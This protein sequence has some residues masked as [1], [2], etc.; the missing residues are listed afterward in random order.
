MIKNSQSL[1]S[2]TRQSPATQTTQRRLSVCVTGC[3]KSLTITWYYVVHSICDGAQLGLLHHCM[4]CTV[5]KELI[6]CIVFMVVFLS[7]PYWWIVFPH[8]IVS[9]H[10]SLSVTKYVVKN[11]SFV[12]VCPLH[13]RTAMYALWS[14]SFQA[15]QCQRA[16]VWIPLE[17]M[18]VLEFVNIHLFAGVDYDIPVSIGSRAL[19]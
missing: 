7:W 16:W 10:S 8:R 5:W 11:S 18:I 3:H 14:C 1:K 9:L 15:D 17:A 13:N 4:W 12:S 2:I 19:A 6:V